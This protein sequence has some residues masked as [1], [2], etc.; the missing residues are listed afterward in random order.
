MGNPGIKN[1]TAKELSVR[2]PMWADKEAV[3]CKVGRKSR[4]LIWVG[5]YLVIDKIRTGDVVTIEFPM[6]ET[7]EYHTEPT[8]GIRYTCHFKGNTLVDISPRP[9]KPNWKEMGSDDGKATAVRKGYPIYLRDHMKADKA[10]MKEATRYV[11][12]Y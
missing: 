3:R 4:P 6:V 5:N 2:I 10:P 9:E 8:Y 7:T 11:H 1:K 12:Q